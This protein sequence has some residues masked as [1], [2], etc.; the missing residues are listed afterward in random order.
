ME[1]GGREKVRGGRERSSEW[2]M[3]ME[4]QTEKARELEKD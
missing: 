4:K 2:E 1:G 3:K